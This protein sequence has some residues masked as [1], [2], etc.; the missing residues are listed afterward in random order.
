MEEQSPRKIGF[1]GGIYAPDYKQLSFGKLMIRIP[2]EWKGIFKA[3]K[4]VT[5]RKRAAHF[6]SNYQITN[7]LRLKPFYNSPILSLFA[8][9]GSGKEESNR[10][11]IIKS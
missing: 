1:V 4:V 2:Q 11:A 9:K 7:T 5:G 10:P 6:K 3:A 8:V